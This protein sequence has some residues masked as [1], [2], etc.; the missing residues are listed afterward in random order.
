MEA[1]YIVCVLNGGGDSHFLLK[2]NSTCLWFISIPLGFLAGYVLYFPPIIMYFI[3]RSDTFIKCTAGTM[4]MMGY[5]WI[6]DVS[7]K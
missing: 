7:R 6:T 3:M 4:C 5:K 1:N 2:L